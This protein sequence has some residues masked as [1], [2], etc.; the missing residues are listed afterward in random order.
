MYGVYF[1]N[2]GLVYYSALVVYRNTS[3][4]DLNN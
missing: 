4:I 3:L 1:H 2:V